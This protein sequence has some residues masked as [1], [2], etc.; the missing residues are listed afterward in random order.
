MVSNV[1]NQ[2]GSSYEAIHQPESASAVKT[3]TGETLKKFSAAVAVSVALHGAPANAETTQEAKNTQPT[4][5]AET[6]ALF[7]DD[8]TVES[9][10][11]IY[12]HM[13]LFRIM[14]NQAENGEYNEDILNN[15]KNPKD[16]AI[17]KWYVRQKL[18]ANLE[19]LEALKDTLTNRVKAQEE[20][21][22]LKEKE[23]REKQQRTQ[24]STLNIVEKV[25]RNPKLLNDQEVFDVLQESLDIHHMPKEI[26]DRIATLFKN[27]KS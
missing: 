6:R 17:A 1:N 21:L 5:S 12:T 25:E 15:I 16:R 19:E 14:L 10:G 20:E 3:R 26:K 18:Q 24:R 4:I 13:E 11:K 8:K 7:A 2:L 9:G 22:K 27:H 23:L